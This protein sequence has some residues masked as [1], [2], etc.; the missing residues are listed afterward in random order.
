MT[1]AAGSVEE[2]LAEQRAADLPDR[3]A[4]SILDGLPSLDT[5]LLNLDVNLDAAIDAAAPINAAVA[6]N[7][8]VAA[9]IDAA[10]SANIAAV[11]STAVAN[12]PQT[13]GH[14]A[15]PRRRGPRH[16]GSGLDIDQ[17]EAA[18]PEPPRSPSPRVPGP[19]DA[20]LAAEQG[21]DLPDR[22]AMSMLDIGFG[23]ADFDNLAMPIN[24]AFALNFNTNQSI[25]SADADQVVVV[26]QGDAE[27]PA[28]PD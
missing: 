4:M 11:G 1:T 3:E 23:R 24:Q 16:G 10:V 7:A 27:I 13:C 9:P 25:A 15:D 6:A 28:D 22:E 26:D 21:T 5:S 19:T 12:A 17:G 20:E 18:M 14:F 2:E 8:N